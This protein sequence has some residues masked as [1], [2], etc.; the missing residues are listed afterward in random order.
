MVTA[1]R[2]AF[3]VGVAMRHLFEE[4]TIAGLARIV[5][6]L[7]VSTVTMEQNVEREEIEI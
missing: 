6:L 1:L 4:P 2:T 5:D 3:D 7:S